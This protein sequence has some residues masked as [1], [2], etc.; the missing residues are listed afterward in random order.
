MATDGNRGLLPTDGHLHSRAASLQTGIF[1]AEA[2]ISVF[3]RNDVDANAN[4]NCN[5]NANTNC[6]VGGQRGR[7]QHYLLVQAKGKGCGGVYLGYS[8]AVS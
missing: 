7:C 2:D 4:A 5:Y 3:E 6:W 1:T 8:C